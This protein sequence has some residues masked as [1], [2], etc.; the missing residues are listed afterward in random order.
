MSVLFTWLRDRLL[1][2]QARFRF[3]LQLEGEFCQRQ[4]RPQAKTGPEE[5]PPSR[6]Q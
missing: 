4:T 6:P 1:Q 2:F 3:S 5:L